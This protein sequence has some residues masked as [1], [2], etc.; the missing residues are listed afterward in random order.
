MGDPSGRNGRIGV[1]GF[2][3]AKDDKAHKAGKKALKPIDTFVRYFKCPLCLTLYW[4]DGPSLLGE[5]DAARKV[6][7]SDQ[8]APLTPEQAAWVANL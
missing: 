1:S 2:M 3:C 6:R 5:R 7:H 4:H 8:L